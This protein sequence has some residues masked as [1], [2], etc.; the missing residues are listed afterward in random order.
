MAAADSTSRLTTRESDARSALAKTSALWSTDSPTAAADRSRAAVSPLVA[1]VR[2]RPPS[3]TPR[4]SQPDAGTHADTRSAMVSATR[5]GST[6]A[7][8]ARIMSASTSARPSVRR[9]VDCNGRS[10]SARSGRTAGRLFLLDRRRALV[11]RPVPVNRLCVPFGM[12]Q[13][14]VSASIQRKYYH[15]RTASGVPGTSGGA[16][17]HAVYRFHERRTEGRPGP[18]TCSEG[19]RC[20][21]VALAQAGLQGVA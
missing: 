20:R 14:L 7:L 15:I 16:P 18:V 9:S 3:S 19:S 13:I 1:I 4:T 8:T 10:R 12:G 17:F 21:A 6:L 5:S 2:A 11:C